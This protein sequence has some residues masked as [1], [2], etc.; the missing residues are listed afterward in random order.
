MEGEEPTKEGGWLRIPD[1][2][3]FSELTV[4]EK[5]V[6]TGKDVGSIAV[7]LAGLG[8]A[9]IFLGGVAT[10][11][12]FADSPEKIQKQALERIKSDYQVSDM[13]GGD[14]R[15]VEGRLE[16]ATY[17]VQNFEYLRMEFPIQGNMR[18]GRVL[19]EM[20]R[21]DGKGDFRV[22]YIM[23]V[24]GDQKKV[25]EDNRHEDQADRGE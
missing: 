23:V 19:L 10:A 1:G 17:R 9:G 4:A 21:K 3:T 18:R 22:R 16:H 13:V 2:R 7:I 8:L 5:V 14:V 6:E 25:I 15:P 24:V 11:L 20:K 12:F